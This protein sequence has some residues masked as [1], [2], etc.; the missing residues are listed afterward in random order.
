MGSY[1]PPVVRNFHNLMERQNE[2][3]TIKNLKKS[4]NP[5]LALLIYRSTPLPNSNYSPA[6]LLM[7][8]KLRTNLPILNSDLKPKM[9]SYSELQMKEHV[10]KEQLKKNFDQRHEAKLLTPLQEGETVWISDH[11]C[12]GKVTG[13]VGPHSYQVETRFGSLRCN[14]CHLITLPK[15]S[16]RVEEDIDMIPDLPSSNN[17]ATNSPPE[18]CFQPTHTELSIPEV[19]ELPDLQTASYQISNFDYL[20]YVVVS[21]GD[22]VISL[23][24]EM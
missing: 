5:Y 12:V 7:S 22:L 23:V 6:E 18:P 21:S 2:E 17:A 24:R 10:R 19:V 1:T 3:C 14:R 15:E 9:P 11:N 4:D 16:A 20:V 8:R 13:K